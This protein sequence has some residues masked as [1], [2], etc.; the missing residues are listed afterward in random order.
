MFLIATADMS[1]VSRLNAKVTNTKLPWENESGKSFMEVGSIEAWSFGD[2]NSKFMKTWSK[3]YPKEAI[4]V[5]F[6]RASNRVLVGLDCSLSAHLPSLPAVLPFLLPA[7]F[8]LGRFLPIKQIL[9]FKN[10]Y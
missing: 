10:S 3:G 6:D 7:L 9:I 2:S 1:P 8:L 4:T 5:A